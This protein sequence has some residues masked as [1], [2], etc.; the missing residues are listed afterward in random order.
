[1]YG[2][3]PAYVDIS[4]FRAP[5]KNAYFAG[6]G[7]T[8]NGQPP[9][10]PGPEGP[11]APEPEV[12]AQFFEKKNG[13]YY[14]KADARTGAMNLLPSLRAIG[15]GGP[16]PGTSLHGRGVE[17]VNVEP[18]TQEEIAVIRGGASDAKTILESLSAHKWVQAK[19]EE[20]KVI[21]APIWLTSNVPGRSLVAVPE[22]DKQALA[23]AASTP[24][25]GILAEP[26]GI[27]RML[28]SV[29]TLGMAAAAVVVVGGVAFLAT[30]KRRGK[31]SFR[32]GRMR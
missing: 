16:A 19:L 3:V 8:E 6:Y 9:P 12:V 17:I 25:M 15:V 14:W 28:G 24:M 27:S 23:E 7:A 26:G 5:Y 29:G 11:L 4:H 31:P 10:P 13:L 32:F 1:M 2:Q 18:Y 20:G 21:V 30:R 22:D